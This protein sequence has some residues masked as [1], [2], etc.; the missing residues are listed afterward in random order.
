MGSFLSKLAESNSPVPWAGVRVVLWLMAEVDAGDIP[1]FPD[2]RGSA[3]S[4]SSPFRAHNLH[5][6]TRT[7]VSDEFDASTDVRR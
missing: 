1:V 4:L 7:Q 6:C 5:V 3:G 2:V